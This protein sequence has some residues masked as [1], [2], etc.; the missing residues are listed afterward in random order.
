LKEALQNR[1]GGTALH[2]DAALDEL[3]TML[4]ANQSGLGVMELDWRAL[5]RF[6]PTASS[7]RF[8]D[9]ARLGG[10]TQGEESNSDDIQRLL[11]ELPDDALLATFIDMIKV[12]VAEILRAS[13]EKLD[14]HQSMFR[15]GSRLS[16]GSGTR[17]RAGRTVR[18][19]AT[20]HGA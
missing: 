5:Q 2:S 3:E 10:D 19:A 4:L 8:G 1:M 9:L 6:L 11:A 18:R 7:P 14:T 15:N 20:G 16:D 17:H 13:V 12:E